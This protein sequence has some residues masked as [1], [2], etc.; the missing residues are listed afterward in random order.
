MI[1]RRGRPSPK[2]RGRPTPPP[3]PKGPQSRPAPRGKARSAPRGRGR[4]TPPRGKPTSPRGRFG[5]GRPTP[6][7]GKPTPK[8]PKFRGGPRGPQ[9][10]IN[11]ANKALANKA[12]ALPRPGGRAAARAAGDPR[13][14]MSP[15]QAAQF[16][17]SRGMGIDR[18]RGM[19][20][21][22]QRPIP[23]RDGRMANLQ[24][25]LAKAQRL[26][27]QQS[28]LGAF[29]PNRANPSRNLPP[30]PMPQSNYARQPMP[31]QQ[32]QRGMG[33]GPMARGNI[34]QV[35]APQPTFGQQM[36]PIL[37]PIQPG[38]R[39]NRRRARVIPRRR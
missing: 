24:A 34:G 17:R 12:I 22:P 23:N 5:R 29:N 2:G 25:E 21:V 11:L 30:R 8:N 16:N 4:P 6:P 35:Q 27:G 33:R 10:G 31:P 9:E 15:A 20:N 19:G 14:F 7:R 38:Q 18:G 1:R 39:L 28:L 36:R 26:R 37:R 32:I 3:P 13:S